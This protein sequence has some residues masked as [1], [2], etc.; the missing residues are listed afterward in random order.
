MSQGREKV[1]V[2]TGANKGVGFALVKRLLQLPFPGVVYLTA[3]DEA[4]GKE[5]V[6]QLKAQ[7][8]NPNFHLL[9]ISSSQSIERFAD[10]LKRTHGGV[11]VVIA[12]GGA[13]FPRDMTPEMVSETLK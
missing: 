13:P 8:L 1:A 11:D 5:A 9:D 6:Q 12:N 7:G 4:R 3:R 2:V 10:F